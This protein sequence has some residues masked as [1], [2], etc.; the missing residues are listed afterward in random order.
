MLDKKSK[1]PASQQARIE[2]AVAA[3]SVALRPNQKSYGFVFQCVID[4]IEGKENG[5]VTWLQ[6]QNGRYGAGL[7]L[8]VELEKKIFLEKTAIFYEDFHL[9]PSYQYEE[10]APAQPAQVIAF[11]RPTLQQDLSKLKLPQLKE[12]AAKLGIV[13]TGDKRKKQSWVDALTIHQLPVQQAA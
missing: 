6:N 4:S 11:H 7:K 10:E 12:L 13:P 1:I 9:D 2:L 3:L 5:R 8:V